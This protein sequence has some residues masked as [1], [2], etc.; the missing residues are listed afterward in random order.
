MNKQDLLRRLFVATTLGALAACGGS[1][2]SPPPA[3]VP[4]PAP[5]PT[6]AAPPPP[7]PS[8]AP[9]P[10]PVPAPAPAPSAATIGAVSFA[11]RTLELSEIIFS[12]ALLWD[13]DLRFV[14]AGTVCSS[15]SVIGTFNGGALPAP[16][17]AAPLNGTLA[18]NFT[19]CREQGGA[20]R[21]NGSASI[22]YSFTNFVSLDLLDATVVSTVSQLRVQGGGLDWLANGTADATIDGTAS[23]ATV[24]DDLTIAPRRGL[25]F[26][27]GVNGSTASY[28][29]GSVGLRRTVQ[30]TIVSG[31]RY[32]ATALEYV[33]G[34]TGYIA[35]GTLTLNYA[36]VGGSFPGATGQIDVTSNGAAV[37]KIVANGAGTVVVEIGGQQFP[38]AGL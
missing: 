38:T 16:G 10:A 15:G 37:G 26:T 18:A 24:V 8:P 20:L 5:V 2:D 6:P 4:A 34:G 13:D 31:L 12:P 11:F 33:V 30:G 17:T 36:G 9:A 3:Q 14:V 25:T 23:G 32:S 35:N 22:D 27:N 7:T 28:E 19:D 21:F 1:D 29:R